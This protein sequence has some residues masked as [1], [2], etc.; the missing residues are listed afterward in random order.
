MARGI[1]GGCIRK[2]TDAKSAEAV[3]A[4]GDVVDG[5]HLSGLFVV[6]LL[7]R[8]F[9]AIYCAE[10]VDERLNRLDARVLTRPIN[11]FADEAHCDAGVRRDG[12]KARSASFTQAALEM[13]RDRFYVHGHTEYR[14]RFDSLIPFTVWQEE[15]SAD[16]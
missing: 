8:D 9:A 16:D 10:E 12:F 5:R 6:Q 13:V 3:R 1:A 15:Q 2:A 7:D 14:F 4:G 11:E